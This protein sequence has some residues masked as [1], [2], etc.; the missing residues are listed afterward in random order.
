[1]AFIF[2]DSTIELYSGIE[3]TAGQ[4]IAFASASQQNTYFQ[5]H[6]VAQSVNCTYVRKTGRLKVEFPPQTVAQCNYIGFRNASFENKVFFA[7]I[8]DYEYINNVTTEIRY[9]L[10]WFQSFCFDVTYEDCHIDREHLSEL[11]WISAEHNPFAFDHNENLYELSTSE[12]LATGREMENL[13]VETTPIGDEIF[14]PDAPG[15]KTLRYLVFFIAKFDGR[16][17]E[18]TLPDFHKCFAGIIDSDGKIIST[19][20]PGEDTFKGLLG[21]DVAFDISFRFSHAYSLCF[22]DTKYIQDDYGL[23]RALAYLTINGLTQQVIGIYDVSGDD[24]KQYLMSNSASSMVFPESFTKTT[25]TNG[26]FEGKKYVNQKLYLSPYSY[27]RVET[28]NGDAKEY[29][30]ENFYW[31]SQP[32]DARGDVQFVRFIFLDDSPKCILVP[33][34]YKKLVNKTSALDDPSFN[35]NER[36]DNNMFSQI[37]YCTDAYLTFLSNQYMASVG[38]MTDTVYDL[39]S[40]FLATNSD[41]FGRGMSFIGNTIGAVASAATPWGIVGATG[42]AISGAVDMLKQ[43]AQAGDQQE[44]LK[45]FGNLRNMSADEIEAIGNGEKDFGTYGKARKAHIADKYTPPKVDGIASFYAGDGYGPST[46]YLTKVRLSDVIAKAYDKYFSLFG[47]N[48]G[49]VGVPRVCNY[50][51]GSSDQ[52]SIPHWDD[53]TGKTITYIKTS[54]MKVISPMKVVSD[55]I[56]QLFD[57]GVRFLKGDTL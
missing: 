1:M 24:V 46:F 17:L 52:A 35:L 48:S 36:L 27:I 56:E 28:P 47:Y 10:D 23:E 26:D 19:G 51:K 2:P 14:S 8:L 40:S 34:D 39:E 53:T 5:A 21:S 31:M 55:Y 25:I 18:D 4:Q 9:A 42:Q 12:N 41:A 32:A 57:A 45:K 29:K 43:S 22:M 13:V 38:N 54:G 44:N 16:E 30:W 7:R 20:N 33:V 49:R 37:G 11:G 50:V 3:I 15:W 6:R